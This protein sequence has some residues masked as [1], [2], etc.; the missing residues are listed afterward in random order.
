MHQEIIKEEQN[1]SK[2]DIWSLGCL[3]HELA[4]LRLPFIPEGD[5]YEEKKNKLKEMILHDNFNKLDSEIYSKSLI[6]IV[7]SMV[8]KAQKIDII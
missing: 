7:N 5:I 8:K 1:N 2:C 3:I 6:N 4:A